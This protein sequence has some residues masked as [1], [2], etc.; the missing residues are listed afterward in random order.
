MKKLLVVIDYQNDFVNGALGFK[1]AEQLEEGIYNK[2]KEYLNAGDNVIFTYDTH[3]KEYLNTREG[4]NLPVSHCIINTKGHDLY[5]KLQE[6]KDNKNI[7]HINKHSFGISPKDM[8][9]IVEK[10]GE[11]IGYIEIVG[12]VTNICVLSNVVTFQ[13]QYINAEISVDASL[14]ASFDEGLHEKTLDV[15]ESLQVK[16]ECINRILFCYRNFNLWLIY[17]EKLFY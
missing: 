8:I 11:D 16:K 10:I 13:S 14:C 1:K 7:T 5:G 6:F 3:T 2:V 15:I 17:K 4:K 9:N 12:V